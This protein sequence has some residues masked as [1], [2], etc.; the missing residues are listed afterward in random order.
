[1]YHVSCWL[2]S[3]LTQV[4]LSDRQPLGHGNEAGN[5]MRVR[6]VRTTVR[7]KRPGAGSPLTSRHVVATLLGSTV[8]RTVTP[9]QVLS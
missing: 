6:S 5:V 4:P 7:K 9:A 3:D 1:M 2:V 8:I